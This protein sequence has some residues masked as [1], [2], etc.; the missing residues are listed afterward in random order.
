MSVAYILSEID[1]LPVEEKLIVIEES[2]KRLRSDAIGIL[3]ASAAEE[4]ADE[5]R[6]NKELTI[7][8]ILD[9]LNFYEA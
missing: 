9:G 8:T 1:K 5:Y 2:V 4:L 3:V 6:I 7:F